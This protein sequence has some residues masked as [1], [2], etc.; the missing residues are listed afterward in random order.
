MYRF[1][2]QYENST[3]VFKG[4]LI[5]KKNLTDNIAQDIIK[6]VPAFANSFEIIEDEPKI[7]E[8]VKPKR[9]PKAKKAE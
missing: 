5:T 4:R 7:T 1:K 8:E 2:K 6:N 3:I 9:I